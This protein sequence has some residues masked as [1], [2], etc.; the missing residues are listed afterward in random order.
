MLSQPSIK[1]YSVHQ[2]LLII[3]PVLLAIVEY[4]TLGKMLALGGAN[5][6]GHTCFAS[7]VKWCF[8]I[9]D[10]VC[11]LL[12]S[13]GGGLYASAVDSKGVEMARTLLLA[14]LGAQLV[15]FSAFICLTI[16]V[17]NSKQYGFKNDKAFRPVFI[18][19]YA[20]TL[21]M[22]L[23]NC[24]RV[25]EFAEGLHGHLAVTE[26]FLYVFDFA[27][28]YA[29]F[30]LFTVMHYGFW[31]G[32]AAP[33]MLERMEQQRNQLPVDGIVLVPVQPVCRAKAMS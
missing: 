14:G 4:I 19:L 13:T 24:F 23:R 3:S 2:A 9:S 12:Q 30:L 8:T 22:Q 25:A 7:W 32:P 16:Y 31:V 28:I 1:V 20:T 21:L 29:C 27:P 6:T 10:I 18:C 11:L 5:S 26:S 15:F 17:H 33:A